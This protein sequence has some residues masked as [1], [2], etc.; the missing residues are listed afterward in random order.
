MTGHGGAVNPREVCPQLLDYVLAG[1]G[2]A[3]HYQEP[4][5]AALQ[6]GRRGWLSY[7]RGENT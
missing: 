3:S 6:D 4:A 7:P 2:G 5:G 1:E